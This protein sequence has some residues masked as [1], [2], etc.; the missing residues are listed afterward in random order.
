MSSAQHTILLVEDDPNDALLLQRTCQCLNLA[1]PL[2]IVS[3]G[4]TA[5]AYLEGRDHFANRE[6]F[7]L[8]TLMLLDLKLPGLSGFEVLTWVRQHPRWSKLQVVV[9]TGSRNSLDLYRAF[10]LGANSY[11]AKPVTEEDILRLTESPGVP[12][13][14]LA[15][16]HSAPRALNQGPSPR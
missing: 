16:S 10:E 6:E 1:K 12:W 5:I 13:L 7:P 15:E 4:E 2:Q 3:T 8:P 11:L 14:A 9:L